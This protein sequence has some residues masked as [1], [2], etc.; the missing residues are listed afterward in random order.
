MRFFLALANMTISSLRS[1][2]HISTLARPH[3]DPL[4]VIHLDVIIY[5]SLDDHESLLV[6]LAIEDLGTQNVSSSCLS[7]LSGRLGSLVCLICLILCCF[8]IEGTN[9]LFCSG[10]QKLAVMINL[11]DAWLSFH[12]SLAGDVKRSTLN[13]LQLLH[14]LS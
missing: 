8:L 4:S 1:L 13:S 14:H 9:E 6:V 2:S 3:Q 7:A 11:V 10:V 12:F 5:L